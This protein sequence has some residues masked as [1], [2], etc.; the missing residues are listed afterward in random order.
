MIDLSTPFGALTLPSPVLLAS[1]TC[2]YAAELSGLVD[3]SAVGGVVTK[4]ISPAPRLGNP[5]PRMCETAA[6]MINSIGL[7]NVGVSGFA[8]TK[9][10]ALRD[11]GIPVIVNFFGETFEEYVACAAEL[12]ALGAGFLAGYALEMNISCPNIKKG[13]VEFGTDPEVAKKLVRACREVC[14]VPLWVKLTPN[15]TDVVALA[16]AV[17]DG[18]ADG[19]SIIN[20]ITAM[21][22]NAATRRPRI[23]TVF[24]GLSGPAIKPIALRMVY[25]VAQANLGVPICGIGGITTAED[26]AEFLIA[27][28]SAVQVGTQTFAEPGAGARIT[29]DLV[30]LAPTLG[31]SRT[32]DLVGTLSPAMEGPGSS[33][34]GDPTCSGG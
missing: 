30:D 33:P 21:A 1:G 8:T 29:G 10:P 18:G 17:V 20:T 22:I 19:L 7:E 11:L 12:S 3:F 28:A 14:D 4:G 34:A 23:A 16:R 2:G 25:Q 5:V 24:G 31:V 13:G 15:V 27:G 26:V 9:A 32:R 6:G